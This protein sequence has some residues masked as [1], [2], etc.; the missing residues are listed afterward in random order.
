MNSVLDLMF[1]WANVE[2][3][4]NHSIFPSLW[5]LS[6]HAPLVVYIAIKKERVHPREEI[7]YF[8]KQ[9]GRLS[10]HQW[11]EEYSRLYWLD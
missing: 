3:F 4:N 2:E 5:G 10:I 7:S 9:W 11:V 6:D 1:F 8:Q